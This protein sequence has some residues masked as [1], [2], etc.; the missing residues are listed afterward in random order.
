M[1]RHA[2]NPWIKPDNK[3]RIID[4]Y[5][6]IISYF[7]YSLLHNKMFLIIIGSL[8]YL[9]I[10]YELISFFLFKTQNNLI[11]IKGELCDNKDYTISSRYVS[12]TPVYK[13]TYNGVE[14]TLVSYDR[15]LPYIKSYVNL[16]YDPKNNTA[17]IDYFTLYTIRL[18]VYIF[19]I[20]VLYY[21]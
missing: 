2:I 17:Y 7:L 18:F 8:I 21:D 5:I 12:F 1:A 4:F 3:V 9:Y 14:E 15:M 10:I 11:R 13:Y 6:P 16:Y 19:I 20:V